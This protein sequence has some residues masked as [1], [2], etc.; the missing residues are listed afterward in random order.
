MGSL[1]FQRLQPFQGKC[2]ND[3]QGNHISAA[4][5]PTI[6]YFD[7]AH[8]QQSYTVSKSGLSKYCHHFS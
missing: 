2:F 5:C 8:M 6:K 4:N 3:G 7:D 1:L